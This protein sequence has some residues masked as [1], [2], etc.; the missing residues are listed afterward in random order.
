MSKWH[1]FLIFTLFKVSISAQVPLE[2]DKSVEQA[3]EALFEDYQNDDGGEIQP[4][5]L[6]LLEDLIQ[7]PIDLNQASADD[8]AVFFFL[9]DG[10]SEAIVRHRETY[11]RFVHPLELQVIP[12]MDIRLVK[13]MLPFVTVSDNTDTRLHPSHYW[14]SGRRELTLRIES[15]FQKTRGFHSGSNGEPSP[16]EGD[17]NRIL[18]RLRYFSGNKISYGISFE[19]DSGE[20]FFKGS[21]SH[22]FDYYSA[23]IYIR[24]PFKNCTQLALGDYG[25]NLGQGLIVSTGFAAGKSALITNIKRVQRNIFPMNSWQESR[26]F[27]GA[28]AEWQLH[29]QWSTIAFASIRNR[30][31]NTVITQ[32]TSLSEI[33]L[34][35]TSFQQ[36]GLHR[37]SAEIA[38]EG[39]FKEW[40]AGGGLR[41]TKKSFQ[42]GGQ[43]V[44]HH[45]NPSFNPTYQPY[46]IA[47]FRGSSLLSGSVDFQAI[48]ARMQLFGEA[49]ISH[50]GGYAITTGLLT[51]P[52]RNVQIALLMRHFSRDFWT[53]WAAPFAE[54][55]QPR[56]ET[57]LY[58]GVILRPVY[59]LK[60]SGFVDLWNYPN[61]SF[62]ADGPSTG[63]E[64]I[65][66]VDYEIRRKWQVYA[67]FR[68]KSR[69]ANISGSTEI[70]DQVEQYRQQWRLQSQYDVYRTM[71]L[72]TRVEM[73][74]AQSTG[75]VERGYLFAQDIIIRPLGSRI[76][77]SGR[78]A[79]FRTD[80]YAS[81][82]YM[83]ENDLLYSFGLRPYYYHGER[84]YINIRYSPTHSLT[85]EG[86]YEY[87]RLFNRDKIGSGY[88]EINGPVRSLVKFQ[89]RY[90]F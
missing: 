38:D 13:L 39:G 73:T 12:G 77:A 56:N 75:S 9:I 34:H 61:I 3:V 80:G 47:Y 44:Y 45:Y 66:R 58:A 78:Y 82:I 43:A 29:P 48:M 7:K 33:S 71:T 25:L 27:R 65:L 57:G 28:A 2:Q 4:E 52:A 83:F 21:N 68:R 86:R 51:S 35:V 11:G 54:S 79:L 10:Q 6:I 36:S 53:V 72:R 88:N 5:W 50:N 60:V 8:L 87:Y 76:S 1:F 26:F 49:A 30:D 18:G 37:T 67:Q 19:K 46:N 89:V 41:F 62:Q 16:F 32:D 74:Q 17:P 42:L 23:H 55:T 90:N 40:F 22:G 59:G 84:S 85:I 64:Q 20:A 24:R 15:P 81:R 31:G 63:V 69:T 14:R 70:P